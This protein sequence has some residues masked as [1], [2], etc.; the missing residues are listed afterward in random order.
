[1]LVVAAR[2]EHEQRS[3]GRHARTQELTSR[4]AQSSGLPIEQ[5]AGPPR[6]LPQH[7]RDRNRVVLPVGH[8]AQLD[9]EMLGAFARAHAPILARRARCAHG[10]SSAERGAAGSNVFSQ[11]RDRKSTRLNSSHVSI[12][13]AVFCLKKKTKSPTCRP[14]PA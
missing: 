13:Y 9:R 4:H 12:S 2:V 10:S 6:R 1:T 3:C 14:T 11:R 7:G 8:R 5:L